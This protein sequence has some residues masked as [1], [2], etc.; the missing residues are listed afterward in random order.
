MNDTPFPFVF[1]IIIALFLM[2]GY[3]GG[4]SDT[5]AMIIENCTVTQEHKFS[6]KLTIDCNVR[7]KPTK[8]R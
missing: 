7:S 8:S 5:E 1:I 2:A 4:V 6:E 3:I